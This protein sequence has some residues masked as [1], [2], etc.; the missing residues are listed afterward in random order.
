MDAGDNVEQRRAELVRALTKAV[1]DL[2]MFEL[3][4]S[5]DLRRF[6]RAARAIEMASDV[7]KAYATR[8]SDVV[9]DG[10]PPADLDNPGMMFPEDLPGEGMRAL[11]QGVRLP[12]ARVRPRIGAPYHVGGLLPDLPP[13][14]GGA[15]GSVANVANLLTAFTGAMERVRGTDEATV[16]ATR[17]RELHRARAEVVRTNAGADLAAIDR[18]I[19]DTLAELATNRVPDEPDTEGARP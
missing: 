14:E 16:L 15:G 13:L 2:V 10:Q 12:A 7:E 8:V 18:E 4:T 5:T 6:A 17:L 9:V 19:A 11:P 3:N 1:G